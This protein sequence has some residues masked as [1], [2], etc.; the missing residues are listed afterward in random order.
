MDTTHLD[1]TW[2][3]PPRTEIPQAGVHTTARGVVKLAPGRY[4]LRTVAD[5]AVW[6]FL[7]GVMILEDSVP[8]ESR[9]RE[10]EFTA[11][12]T[13]ELRVEHWQKDGWYELRVDVDK[14]E[15]ER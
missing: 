6:V 3:R 12:G 7:D 9:V 5:D 11:T 2:Y 15:G 14:T 10:V 13:H 8:G 4:M 1:L